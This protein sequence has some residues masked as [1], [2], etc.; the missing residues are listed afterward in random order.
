M[1]DPDPRRRACDELAELLSTPEGLRTARLL[2]LTEALQPGAPRMSDSAEDRAGAEEASPRAISIWQ[3]GLRG[4]E[5]AL[6]CHGSEPWPPPQRAK[7]AS[8]P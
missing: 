5:R 8:S 4:D 2:Q 1:N 7:G 6:P 3:P